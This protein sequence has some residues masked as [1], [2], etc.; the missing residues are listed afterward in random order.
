MC[1][2]AC[3]QITADDITESVSAFSNLNTFGFS[4]DGNVDVDLN[5]HKGKGSN[6]DNSSACV[7]DLSD[8]YL[9]F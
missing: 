4:L 3:A 5:M 8:L 9:N 7:I 2:Y 6:T 1:V